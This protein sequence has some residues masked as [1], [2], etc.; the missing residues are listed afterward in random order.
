MHG[1]IDM[2]RDVERLVADPAFGGTPTGDCLEELCR[3]YVIPLDWHVGFRIAV[4]DVPDE[5]R[6]PAIW[7]L[8]RRIAGD[9]IVDAAAIG[10]VQRSLRLYPE[11][12]R[13]WGSREDILQHLKQLWHVLVHYGEPAVPSE[14]PPS[15]GM[16]P[17]AQKTRRGQPIATDP[18]LNCAT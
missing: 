2:A 12:W 17:T 4:Q 1:P 14:Q 18:E 3:K 6:G 16:Q 9:G 15:R 13:D 11:H 5:L 10:A 8:A 7:R